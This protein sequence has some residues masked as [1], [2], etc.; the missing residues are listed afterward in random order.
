MGWVKT[1]ALLS[2]PANP[3]VPFPSPPAPWLLQQSQ[4]VDFPALPSTSL[5]A[6]HPLHI[7]P[8]LGSKPSLLLLQSFPNLLC[9]GLRRSE[10]GSHRQINGQPLLWGCQ[11]ELA[12]RSSAGRGRGTPGTPPCDAMARQQ[13]GSPR[14]LLTFSQAI[15]MENN[16]CMERSGSHRPHTPWV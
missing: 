12:A 4:A 2:S 5:L 13:G 8:S 16:L 7:I 3:R 1:L 15:G 11:Q 9:S 14:S 10:G 6:Q